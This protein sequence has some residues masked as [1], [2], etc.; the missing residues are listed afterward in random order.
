MMPARLEPLSI[1]L[2]RLLTRPARQSHSVRFVFRVGGLDAE[3]VGDV[4]P[5]CL[6]RPDDS[7][8]LAPLQ[9]VVSCDGVVQLDSGQLGLLDPV[10]LEQ[11]LL[12]LLGQDLVLRHQHVLGD[13]DQQLLLLELLDHELGR[14]D[15]LQRALREGSER[16]GHHQDRVRDTRILHLLR[17]LLD[18]L[19]AHLGLLGKKHE[20]LLLRVVLVRRVNSQLLLVDLVPLVKTRIPSAEL[21][22][23]RVFREVE[24]VRVHDI[25]PVYQHLQAR[26]ADLEQPRDHVHLVFVHLVTPLPSFARRTERDS[27]PA[28]PRSLSPN[29]L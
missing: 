5:G 26:P 2:G 6:R 15:V 20:D 1:C 14:E 27:P 4:P 3:P 16:R 11:R 18:L 21:G 13:V 23:E 29:P 19:H 17:V 24:F 10:A 25:P 8:D 7:D 22:S 12:L 9:A 28:T